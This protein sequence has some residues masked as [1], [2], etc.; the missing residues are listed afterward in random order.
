MPE[1][2]KEITWTDLIKGLPDPVA[3]PENMT[4]DEKARLLKLY[5]FLYRLGLDPSKRYIPGDEDILPED[6]PRLH[7]NF[8][9]QRKEDDEKYRLRR[10]EQIDFCVDSGEK[11]AYPNYEQFVEIPGQHNTD[12]WLQAVKQVYY[13]IKKGED[14]NIALRQATSGWKHMEIFDFLNW[15]RYYESGNQLK[16]KKAQN[17]YGDADVGYLLPIKPDKQPAKDDAP[18]IKGMSKKKREEIENQ[19]KKIIGRLDSAEKLIRSLEGQELAEEQFESLL[20]VLHELKQKVY[21]VN[22]KSTSSKIYEDMI[23]REANILTSKGLTKA[24]GL[25]LYA[26]DKAEKQ[27]EPPLEPPPQEEKKEEGTEPAMTAEPPLAPTDET[28]P[29]GSGTVGGL[30]MPEGS[31]GNPDSGNN[32]PAI[33]QFLKGLETGTVSDSEDLEVDDADDDLVV[34]A[35]VEGPLPDAPPEPPPPKPTGPKQTDE[36]PLEIIEEDVPVD[37]NKDL[38]KMVE[39]VFSNLTITEVVSK[40]EDIAK[41]YKT[42]EM[43]RQLALADMMLDSLGLAPFFPSL[44]EATNKALEANNYIL[45]RIEE[46]IARLR[47]T[48]KTKDIDMTG[49]TT[50]SPEMENITKKL[51]EQDRKEKERKEK[52]QEAEALE[53]EKEIPEVEVTEDLEVPKAPPKA[54]PPAPPKAAPPRPA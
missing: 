23:I 36:E 42:R 17:W 37:P 15:L 5:N 49:E 35:Q 25:F 18:E 53:A 24:A 2:S 27:A 26:L 44:S 30:P 31:P 33:S 45:T 50:Q 14:R 34:E 11:L 3:D 8:S 54:P 16:Y 47:G 28:V 20:K 41:F 13:D 51:E 12:K 52:R 39:S 9:E 40:F 19:R 7:T 32:N 22:K 4:E 6:D 10:K 46:I 21:L 48:L 29:T 38:D 43:A 1:E